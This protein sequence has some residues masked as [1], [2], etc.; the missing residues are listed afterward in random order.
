MDVRTLDALSVTK[1]IIIPYFL[2]PD[3]VQLL[4]IR[5]DATTRWEFGRQG[6]GY[7]KSD[8]KPLLRGNT[9]FDTIA[10][11]ALHLLG[12]DDG[13][14]DMWLLRY[15]KGSCVPPHR[16]EAVFGLRHKRIN[17]MLTLPEYGGH[18]IADG[19]RVDLRVGDAV[20]FYPD[21]VTHEVTKVV[22]D[23][24]LVLSIGVLL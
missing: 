3:E 20:M 2:A 6:T 15:P 14:W 24:R 8:M 10:G 7:E 4:R 19:E 21:S 16:D 18:F 12:P 5:A 1:I 22:T 13:N 23:S 9:T 11:R 17:A